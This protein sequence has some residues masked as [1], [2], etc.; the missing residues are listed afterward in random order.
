MPSI[1]LSH[2]CFLFRNGNIFRQRCAQQLYDSPKVKAKS[3][4]VV[5][6]HT[7]CCTSKTGILVIT[8]K[9]GVR[10]P[11]LWEAEA[12]GSQVWAHSGQF[13]DL[14]RLSAFK[15]RERAGV[16]EGPSSAQGPRVHSPEVQW[17]NKQTQLNVK[18]PPTHAWRALQGH[19]RRRRHLHSPSRSP[20][21]WF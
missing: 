7:H 18:A 16:E 13:I 3:H 17:I 11:T 6:G 15:K 20:H 2:R 12:E 19:G 14:T 9:Q 10:L 4:Q 5:N 1:P 8:R 21:S